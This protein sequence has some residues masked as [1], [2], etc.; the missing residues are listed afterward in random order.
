MV[1]KAKTRI[2]STNRLTTKAFPAQIFENLNRS[3]LNTKCKGNKNMHTHTHARTHTCTHTHM[4]AHTHMHTHTHTHTHT[5]LSC[6]VQ[7]GHIISFVAHI[8]APPALSYSGTA[9][10]TVALAR[11]GYSNRRCVHCCDLGQNAVKWSRHS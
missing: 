1:K 5:H 9:W 4:H 3:K 11:G 7:H 10:Y 8:G 2:I 6:P